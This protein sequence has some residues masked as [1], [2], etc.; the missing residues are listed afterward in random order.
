MGRSIEPDAVIYRIDREGRIVF[1]N[2]RWTEFALANDAASLAR[3]AGLDKSLWDF[4]AD[5]QTKHLYRTM[6]DL[7]PV[8]GDGIVIPLRCDS[9]DCRRFIE[10]RIVR[11]D[12]DHVEFAAVVLRTERREPVALL[13][14]QA[15]RSEQWL[16]MCSGCK[17]VLAD[18]WVEIEEAV[19]RLELF[20][21]AQLPALT[22]GICPA[23]KADCDARIAANRAKRRR[24]C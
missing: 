6:L 19:R 1:V 20:A 22:H 11:P 17:K 3:E 8:G 18:A 9:P 2:E 14:A 12:E 24:P 5:V 16:R 21:D 4:V 7:L 23:C 13:D 15:A 10:L